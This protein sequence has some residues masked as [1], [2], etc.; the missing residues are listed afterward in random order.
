MGT[1]KYEVQSGDTLGAIAQ[2]NSTTVDKIMALNPQ[3][4]N[5]NLI[6]VGQDITIP[7]K[8]EEKKPKIEKIKEKIAKIKAKSKD[9]KPED[10]ANKSCRII[11]VEKVTG[12]KEIT[13]G[14]S[15]TYEIT[16]YNRDDLTDAEKKKVKWKVEIYDDCNS[17][18]SIRNIDDCSTVPD[19]FEIQNDKLIIKKV[20]DFWTCCIKVY[21]YMEI[22]T[23]AV[24][25]VSK[26]DKKELFLI[27]YIAEH[28]ILTI[29][30]RMFY[31]AAETRINNIKNS[32]WYNKECHKVHM[33]PFGPLD[34]I[35]EEVSSYIKK[36]GGKEKAFVKEVSIFSHSGP[37]DGP[38]SADGGVTIDPI[39]NSTQMGLNGWG[40]IDFNWSK[41]NPIFAVLGCNA[42]RLIKDGK[43]INPFCK[44]ISKLDNFKD[45]PIWGQSIETVPS[46]YPDYR[47]TVVGRSVGPGVGW[48]IG[49]HTYLVGMLKKGDGWKAMSFSTHSADLS[50]GELKEYPTVKKM[51]IFKN[52]NLI[53]SAEQKE[54]NDHQK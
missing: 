11:R 46:M 33:I 39:E 51:N 3:I 52:G 4:K 36:Y 49:K 23:I 30:D 12:P 5:K 6:M 10:I 14:K 37:G 13:I 16:K 42:G 26:I 41:N 45:V 1:K 40:S 32:K 38:V 17:T 28:Y 9:S 50:Q 53:R 20:P 27:F 15:A 24:R 19:V 29:R 47:V 44:R 22:P 48:D 18:T 43:K 31:E 54:F 25:Q 21:P 34:E 35:I 8:E 7:I 2:Q